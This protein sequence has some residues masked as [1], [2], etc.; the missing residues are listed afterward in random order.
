MHKDQLQNINPNHVHGCHPSDFRDYFGETPFYLTVKTFKDSFPPVSRRLVL[1][2]RILEDI[3][4]RDLP[5]KDYFSEYIRQKYRHN[6]RPNTLRQAAGSLMQFLSFYRDTGKQY[7]EQMTRQDIEAFIEALQDRGL[8]PHSVRT[9]LCGVYAFIRFLIEK[10]AVGH[11]LLERRIKL[12]LPDRLPRA[13]DSGDLKQLLSVVD[14][15]S[16]WA[17][18]AP[19]KAIE[20]ILNIG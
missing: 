10:K 17:G 1:L 3:S 4:G 13:I 14:N 12:K 18:V 15:I 20:N 9:R 2:K 16:A 5:A 19:R 6:C 11:E 7:P 8:A